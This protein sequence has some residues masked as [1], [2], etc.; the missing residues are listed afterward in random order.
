[1]PKSVESGRVCVD[2][3]RRG[4]ML[5]VALGVA[6][7]A[8]QPAAPPPEKPSFVENGL[9]SWYGR[10]HDGKKTA[11]GEPFNRKAMTAAHRTLAFGSIVRVTA[12]ESGAT[13]KVRIND[14]GPFAQGRIIDLSEAAAQTLGVKDGGIVAVR[15]E[16][17]ESD[18]KAG[19]AAA[20]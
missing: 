1:M 3:W 12:T 4:A 14:R 9:A 5:V 8:T 7:C 19:I 11:S 6:A 18:Q 10:D 17:Y 2:W 20:E 15:I 13:T 16:M